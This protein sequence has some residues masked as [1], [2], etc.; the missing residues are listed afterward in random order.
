MSKNGTWHDSFQDETPSV[1]VLPGLRLVM[2]PTTMALA[3]GIVLSKSFLN[4]TLLK[5]LPVL[6]DMFVVVTEIRLFICAC[7]CPMDN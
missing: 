6:A 5:Y 4:Y 7:K 1:Y 2:C 3:Y